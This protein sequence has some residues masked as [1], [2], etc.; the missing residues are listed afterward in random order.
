MKVLI[1]GASGVT[2]RLVV[3]QIISRNI[4]TKIVI[5]D[6]EKVSKDI[7][8]NNLVECIAGNIS[9]FD[10]ENNL[11]IVSGCDAVISCLGHNISFKGIYGKPRLL[12]MDS[13]KNVCEALMESKKHK[14]KL[15]LMN[16]TANRNKKINEK[17]SF[18]DRIVLSTLSLV[19]PPQKDNE[20]AAGYLSEIIGESSQIIE[21]I[22]IRPDTLIDEDKASNYE[23]FESPKQSPVFNSGKTSRINVSHFITE[24]LTD[25]VLWE[26]WKYK[27]PVIYNIKK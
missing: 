27:M 20:K 3:Q 18:G 22:A 14:V 5:R 1:L 7:R 26:R 9:E 25:E 2:G 23:L 8:S 16:T 17:Y 15:I 19:L 21:W 13:I 11:K 24:L 6:I 12:V 10:H 4:E